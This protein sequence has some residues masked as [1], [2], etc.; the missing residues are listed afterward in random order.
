MPSTDAEQ[1]GRLPL[2][3]QPDRRVDGTSGR[4][5]ADSYRTLRR[6]GWIYRIFRTIGRRGRLFAYAAI[7]ELMR[8]AVHDM[9]VALG[10]S[11][12]TASWRC[13]GCRG[14]GRRA[15][16]SLSRRAPDAER[17]AAA[18]E[19]EARHGL[20]PQLRIGIDTGARD[21]ANRG[22]DGKTLPRSATRPI[23]PRDCNSLPSPRG[24][25]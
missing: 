15:A 10:A 19:I 16:K 4:A 1:S 13:L 20:R 22:V 9:A 5:N 21:G 18:A 12:A 24:S 14:V 11:P 3:V 2:I 7:S 23:W 25:S 8:E 6:S 17:L